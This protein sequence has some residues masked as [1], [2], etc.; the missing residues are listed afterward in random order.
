MY[1][2]PVSYS[3]AVIGNVHALLWIIPTIMPKMP[4]AEAKISTIKILTNRD[5]S[6][7]SPTAQLDPAIPTET[8]DAILVSPTDR[9]EENMP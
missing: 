6:W 1:V 5:E 8:P 4:R 9:P 3:R 7:A 2:Q